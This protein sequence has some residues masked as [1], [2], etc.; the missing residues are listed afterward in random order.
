MNFMQSPNCPLLWWWYNDDTAC[1]MLRL[2]QK[3]M[4]FSKT[5]KLLP[6]SDINL[7]GIPYSA[8]MIFTV[9][10]RFSADN[11]SIL[12]CYD[13]LQYTNNFCY[14]AGICLHLTPPMVSALCHDVLSSPWAV[15]VEIQV[16]CYNLYMIFYV[17]INIDPVNR[18]THE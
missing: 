7:H 17:I 12:I 13:N 3:L 6:A 2:L 9:M 11:P 15:S 14:S 10:M 4:N 5:K 16:M 8:N 18:F 1:S